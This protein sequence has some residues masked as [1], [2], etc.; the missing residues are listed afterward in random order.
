M[1]I[2]D[3]RIAEIIKLGRIAVSAIPE[4]LAENAALKKE[5][6]SLEKKLAAARELTCE[7]PCSHNCC[8]YRA[9]AVIDG[10]VV[11]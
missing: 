10:K 5:I 9:R 1:K 11:R 3:D 8:S 4:L 7:E 2:P 6:E